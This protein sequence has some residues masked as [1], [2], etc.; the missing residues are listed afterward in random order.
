MKK[1]PL[2]RGRGNGRINVCLD[3]DNPIF[4]KNI[5]ALYCKACGLERARNR[6]R[7]D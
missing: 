3:C 4:G 5:N 1:K 7:K 2:F 6:A